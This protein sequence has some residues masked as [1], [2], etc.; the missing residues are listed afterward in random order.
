MN[1]PR[2]SPRRSKHGRPMNNHDRRNRP[3]KNSKLRNKRFSG[4]SD[5]SDN[6]GN[7]GINGNFTIKSGVS[8]GNDPFCTIC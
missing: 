3:V 5:N 2:K 1:T 4:I 8:Y 6:S 7:T